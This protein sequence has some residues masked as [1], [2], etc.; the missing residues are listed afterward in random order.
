[1]NLWICRPSYGPSRP[2]SKSHRNPELPPAPRISRLMSPRISDTACH[3]YT[4]DRC[5]KMQLMVEQGE[6]AAMVYHRFI[7]DD[8]KTVEF[9]VEQAKNN[10]RETT[11]MMAVRPAQRATVGL[12]PF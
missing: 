7:Y 8:H 6:V 5:T 2:V 1:M 4:F 9:L 11:C 12:I 10:G 3:R